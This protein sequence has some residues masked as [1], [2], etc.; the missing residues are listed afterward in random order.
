M[1]IAGVGCSGGGGQGR[2]RN[3]SVDMVKLDWEVIARCGG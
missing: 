1:M 3:G 2:C